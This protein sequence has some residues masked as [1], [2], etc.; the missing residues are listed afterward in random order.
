MPLKG[1]CVSPPTAGV[2]KVIRSS[3]KCQSEAAKRKMY[4]VVVHVHDYG[5]IQQSSFNCE[6]ALSPINRWSPCKHAWAVVH[7]WQDTDDREGKPA[8]RAKKRKDCEDW[9]DLCAYR[10]PRLVPQT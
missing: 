2:N 8:A 7:Q 6:Y 4:Q 1:L 3:S 10:R 9:R 5:D